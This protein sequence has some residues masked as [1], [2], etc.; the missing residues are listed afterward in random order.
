VVLVD[1]SVPVMNGLARN[2]SAALRPTQIGIV[3][4]TGEAP[5]ARPEA[6]LRCLREGACGLRCCPNCL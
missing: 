1:L 2:G 5:A 6:M 3:M 4:V